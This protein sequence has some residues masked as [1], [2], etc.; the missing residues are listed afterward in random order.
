MRFKDL[1]DEDIAYAKEIYF[2]KELGKFDERIAILQEFFGLASDRTTR[3]WTAKLGWT[4]KGGETISEQFIKAQKKKHD[5]KKKCFLVTW[6]QNDTP[7]HQGLFKNMEAYAKERNAE[8]LVIAGRYRNPTSLI[9]SEKVKNEDTWCDEILPYLDANRHDIH[10]NFSILS[11][12]KVQPTTVS[13]ISGIQ[14]FTDN[15]SCIIGSPR[16]QFETIPVLEGEKPKLMLS[17][18]ALTIPNYTDSKAGKKGE[19]H[20]IFGFAVVEIQDKETFYVRQITADD[21]TGDF[22]DLTNHVKSGKIKKNKSITA[23]ILGDIH[24]GEEDSDVIDITLNKLLKTLT[25]KHLVLHD[26]FNGHSISHH[27]A[28]DVFKRYSR[29]SDGSNS[30]KDEVNYMIEWLKKVEKY[31]VIVVRSNHDD[32]LDRWLQRESLTKMNIKNAMEYVK[33]SAI[34]LSGKAPKGIIPYL[35]NQKYPKM[36]TLDMNSS[37]KV[38]GWELAVHSH[39]GSNGAKGNITNFRRLNSKLIIAHSH[40]PKIMENVVQVGTSTRLRVGYN[41]GPSSWLNSHAIIHEDSK[42]Q[43]INIIRD[44]KG[45]IGYTTL[46]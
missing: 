4:Q 2:D 35:I 24:L 29:E 23:A 16:K 1:T 6:A 11:D 40:S 3:K 31:N 7:I 32:F 45:K 26:V 39:A 5:K 37:F 28:K 14:G 46:Q 8:I 44:A 13:A 10:K 12:V 15:K 18:G 19:F 43:L 27:E 22:Y 36:K 33:Y 34:L 9:Q 41:L 17:T 38:K 20:H 42:C 21:K 30:L 25:P